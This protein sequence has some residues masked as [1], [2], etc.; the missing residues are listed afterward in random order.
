MSVNSFFMIY[1]FLSK[2]WASY[3]LLLCRLVYHMHDTNIIIPE[4]KTCLC[5]IIWM[6]RYKENK[7]S[8][9][10]FVLEILFQF[11]CSY[12]SILYV[13]SSSIHSYSIINICIYLHLHT[14]HICSCMRS[15]FFFKEKETKTNNICYV[16][17]DVRCIVW[18]KKC[19][20]CNSCLV[21]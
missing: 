19:L 10:M 16:F 7:Y 5:L 12:S 20:F 15:S 8:K 18:M 4:R 17:N 6:M 9:V 3:R 13:E 2:V 14:H 21:Y 11:W 1:L